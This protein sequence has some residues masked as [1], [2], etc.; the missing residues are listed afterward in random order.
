MIWYG[1]SPFNLNMLNKGI[2]SAFLKREHFPLVLRMFWFI[3]TWKLVKEISSLYKSLT[4][5]KTLNPNNRNISMGSLLFATFCF[6]FCPFTHFSMSERV[7]YSN[8]IDIAIKSFFV[9]KMRL[10]STY[11]AIL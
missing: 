11:V 5:V 10:P 8:I 9:A 6:L 3:A 1:N 7:Y 4:P 2:Y